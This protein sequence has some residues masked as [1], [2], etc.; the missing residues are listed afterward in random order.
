M[1]KK[2]CLTELSLVRIS[3]QSLL[4]GYSKMNNIPL[5]DLTVTYTPE[6]RGRHGFIPS[7]II[8]A[9]GL[10]CSA[11]IPKGAYKYINVGNFAIE[12]QRVMQSIGWD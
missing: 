8:L 7:I 4:L 5:S 3:E 9:N 2:D 6:W 1:N 12:S 11:M 10:P